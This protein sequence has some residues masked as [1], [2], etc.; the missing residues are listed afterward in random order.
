M[1]EPYRPRAAHLPH[2]DA[3]IREALLA[4]AAVLGRIAKERN[5]G[6][7]ES[8]VHAFERQIGRSAAEGDLLIL[9]AECDGET[10]AFAKA[11][12]H[13][14]RTPEDQGVPEGWYLLGVVVRPAFRRRGVARELTRKRLEWLRTR[15]DEAYYFANAENRV[16]IELH[17]TF[18]FKEVTRDFSYPGVSFAGEEGILF[19][20]D[21]RGCR[22]PSGG[23]RSPVT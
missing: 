5:G 8:H 17:E 19:R 11:G 13:H 22:K 3:A 4:D 16:S 18:G 23:S 15:C 6:D 2:L 21:L 12:L 14:W 20:A 1:F 9:V 10:V 7:L